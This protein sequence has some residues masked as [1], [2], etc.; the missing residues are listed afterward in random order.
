M[1]AS[2][3]GSHDPLEKLV[4]ERAEDEPEPSRLESLYE[5]RAV[6]II[7]FLEKLRDIEVE[8]VEERLHTGEPDDVEALTR[9]FDFYMESTGWLMKMG[10]PLA[11]AVVEDEETVI[12][13][14]RY[15][16]EPPEPIPPYP[17]AA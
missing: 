5:Q 12:E 13:M 6:L 4:E 10:R 1:S 11:E 17:Q 8:I 16:D 2:S 3:F 9:D 15:E 7:E 14:L